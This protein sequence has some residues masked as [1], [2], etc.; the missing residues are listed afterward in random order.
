L[1]CENRLGQGWREVIPG[2]GLGL[3]LR[4]GREH[5]GFVIWKANR[6]KKSAYGKGREGGGKKKKARKKPIRK[7]KA[8]DD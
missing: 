8:T 4:G 6:K 5:V 2:G 7:M 1:G 3:P